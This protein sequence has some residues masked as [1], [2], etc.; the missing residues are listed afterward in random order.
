MWNA[1]LADGAQ[2]SIYTVLVFSMT[3][4]VKS[5]INA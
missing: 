3:V 1:M 5:K 2:L 4:N